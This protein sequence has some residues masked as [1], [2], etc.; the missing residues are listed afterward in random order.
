MMPD[1][2]FLIAVSGFDPGD[3]REGAGA[4]ETTLAYKTLAIS[5][6]FNSY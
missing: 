3:A 1:M 4:E 6:H 2:N 5:Q